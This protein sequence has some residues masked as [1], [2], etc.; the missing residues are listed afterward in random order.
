MRKATL[1]KQLML[2][3]K[4]RAELEDRFKLEELCFPS[5]LA[6]IK[7]TSRF[8]TG[9]CSRRAGKS[10]GCVMHL[11]HQAVSVPESVSLYITLTRQ[12][13]KR[14][15][16]DTL[17]KVNKHFE[18]GGEP[19]LSELSVRFSNGSV[20]YLAGA[21][22]EAEIEKYRGMALHLAYV[23]EAQAFKPYLHTLIH[24][25]LEKAL[26]DYQGSL[27][28]IGT[29]NAA[30]VGTFYDAC[31]QKGVYQRWSKH[32]W[33]M[34]DNTYLHKKMGMN[35]HDFLAKERKEMGIDESDPT[36]QRE[37]LGQWIRSTDQLVYAYS[38]E[39]LYESSERPMNIEWT[40]IMGIDIGFDD[41]DAV[42]VLAYSPDCE[43]VY[44]VYEEKHPHQDITDLASMIKRI[45]AK[46]NCSKKVIDGGALGKKIVDEL[47]R[48]HG[49]TL[50]PAEKQRKFEFIE[51]L[52]A[53]LR[54]GR[55][56]LLD[57]DLAY[58]MKILQRDPKD[59]T[60]EDPR[61]PNHLSDGFLYIW[62]ESLH[63]IGKTP[64]VK[65]EVGTKAYWDQLEEEM[66]AR[67]VAEIESRLSKEWWEE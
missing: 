60:K 29:P 62:R 63:Y 36:Y 23:D 54:K 58:E 26:M 13:A 10:T 30:C 41:D 61:F 44:Q 43:V 24:E 28:M 55:V 5:Q 37:V 6:F 64:E 66:E 42:V 40:Y 17:L 65:P 38:D 48:R 3:L 46:Y 27:V 45:D 19:N 2:E 32:H 53:D 25:I 22:D 50:K 11:L 56:K 12:T 52:N 51:L 39:C 20:I 15:I 33:T 16:W 31:H 18:L 14:N 49:I 47:R 35:I 59:P 9:C 34:V 21:N 67:D 57:G 7:D 8:K 1:Q 4:R